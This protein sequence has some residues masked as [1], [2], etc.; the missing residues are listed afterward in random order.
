MKKYLKLF[1]CAFLFV[2]FVNFF[3]TNANATVAAIERGE[4]CEWYGGN[5]IPQKE[6]CASDW[7]SDECIVGDERELPT[8]KT[9][10][11]QA[12]F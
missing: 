12:T 9:K 1:T 6:I 10:E 3:P 4:W 5:P 8:K 2:L 7:W 11:I